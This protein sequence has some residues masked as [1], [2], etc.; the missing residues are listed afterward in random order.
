MPREVNSSHQNKIL[1]VNKELAA[2]FKSNQGKEF[3]NQKSQVK[4]DAEKYVKEG[5]QTTAACEAQAILKVFFKNEYN[6][7]S[8]KYNDY[9]KKQE[10][11]EYRW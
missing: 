8:A 9:A 7:I 5:G 4:E 6:N 2:F 1:E 11:E 10:Q 3:A